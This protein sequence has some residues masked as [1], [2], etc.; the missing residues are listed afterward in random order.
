MNCHSLILSLNHGNNSESR[1][2][3]RKITHFIY[4]L[5]NN[6]RWSSLYISFTL[7]ISPMF[8]F[9]FPYSFSKLTFF[10]FPLLTFWAKLSLA[11][12]CHPVH[13]RIFSG[14]LSFYPLGDSSTLSTTV[15]TQNVSKHCQMSPGG[16]NCP[17]WAPL[18]CRED[19]GARVITGE[20]GLLGHLP[21]LSQF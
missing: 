19:V 4:L 1:F 15:T 5:C 18:L 11:V 13:Y 16:P 17:S 10:S 7:L 21:P 9:S 2:E 3:S 20:A 6:F 14:F 12:F 8:F